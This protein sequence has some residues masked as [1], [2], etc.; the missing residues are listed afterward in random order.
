MSV[1]VGGGVYEVYVIY[2]NFE[3]RLRFSRRVCASMHLFACARG[4]GKICMHLL[5]HMQ[6][7]SNGTTSHCQIYALL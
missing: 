2:K 6:R 3:Q 5:M 1:C 7:L 4:R